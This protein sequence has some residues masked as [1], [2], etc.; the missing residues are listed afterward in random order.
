MNNVP[1]ALPPAAELQQLEHT[2]A[3]VESH[4]A[5]LLT[6]RAQLLDQLRQSGPAAAPQARWA[7]PHGP[8]APAHGPSA[9]AHGPSAPAPSPWSPAPSPWAA[10]PSRRDARPPT[11]QNVLL[12]LGGVLLAVAVTA[13]T[14][15]S[16]GAMGIG[17]RA[18]VLAVLT[19]TAMGTPAL[20][21]LRRAL[22]ATAEAVACLGLVLLLL[23]AYA[24][25]QVALAAADPA[26]Y[27]ALATAVVAAIWAAYGLW[28]RLPPAAGDA[29][30]SGTRVDTGARRLRLPLPIAVLLAQLPLPLSALAA[31]AGPLGY[32]SALLVTA[33]ADLALALGFRERSVRLA[34]TV[35]AS[36]TGISGALLAAGVSATS[37]G[38]SET[39]RAAALLLLAAALGL[40]GSWRHSREEHTGDGA[41][42]CSPEPPAQAGPA[43]GAAGPDDG[44]GAEAEAGIVTG[45]AA[46]AVPR[47][48]PWPASRAAALAWP[49]GAG[50]LAVVGA[51][52]GLLRTALP[53]SWAVLGYLLSGTVVLVAARAAAAR[54]AMATGLSA[55]GGLVHAGAV[56]WTLPSVATAVLAPVTWTGAVWSGAP[57]GAR[58]ALAPGSVSVDIDWPGTGAVPAVLGV[59]AVTAMALHRRVTVRHR[60][61][62]NRGTASGRRHA[63][64]AAAAVIA[65]CALGAVL[66]VA[67]DLAH[68]VAVALLVAQV[69]VLLVASVTLA[70]AHPGPAAAEEH[71]PTSSPGEPGAQDSA[72]AGPDAGT[73]TE[74]PS[75]AALLS[76]AVMTLTAALWSLAEQP[77]TL[78]ALSGLFVV[79]AAASAAAGTAAWAHV[80]QRVTAGVATACA[81][82]LTVAV[83][84]AADLPPHRTAFTV[85][86]VAAA[87]ATVAARLRA[88]PAGLAVE[89]TG[90]AA[91]LLAI[92][93]AAGDPPI[94]AAVLA[95]AGVVMSSTALRRDRRAARHA[96][97]ALF[98][99]A[100]WSRLAAWDVSAP[101]AY[102][103]PV[104][105]AALFIGFRQRRQDPPVSSWT[106]YGP[107]LGTTLL[108]SLMAVWHDTHWVRPLLLGLAAL[109]VTMVGARRGLQAPLL[110]GGTVLTLVALHELAPYIVQ[111]VDALPRWLP[112]A[113]AGLLLLATGA[114]YEHRLRDA[115]KIRDALGRMR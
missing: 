47:P 66:P 23:D 60:G 56:F 115:R 38:L 7:P 8:S 98:V 43:A 100:A 44:E 114:T 75:L 41:P 57:S 18:A 79:H 87:G 111:V 53:G 24:V 83:C 46:G 52:G 2:L 13:F 74:A 105:A 104:T 101:E 68:P 12:A 33:A 21:L 30:D 81:V 89:C 62:P 55:A 20:L 99:M 5:W 106:A 108:P 107:G 19:L 110:L 16:W 90:Y 42:T 109:A 95:L 40:T 39:A 28:L 96:A 77:V 102:T 97:A 112:P 51:V 50:G 103:L 61:V 86:A 94:F 34:A 73:W 64:F 78:G 15:V 49:A 36:V 91:L 29:D 70:S 35:C 37:P 17:G 67:L 11:V 65:W 25:H 27:S 10:Q 45:P 82:A 6:R 84:A 113:V 69:A 71:P 54:T 92:G 63:A 1:P 22:A 26:G 31:G 85:V 14:V 72:P 58:D 80:R 93:L 48:A 32:G 9:P 76:A 88:L 3:R 4:R 59:L